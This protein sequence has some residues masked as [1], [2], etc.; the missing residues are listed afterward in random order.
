MTLIASDSFNR[1]NSTSAIGTADVGGTWSVPMP[2]PGDSPWGIASSKAY[3]V[4]PSSATFTTIADVPK[5][6]ALLGST[7]DP[8]IV[9]ADITFS[10]TSPNV[11]LVAKFVDTSN[12]IFVDLYNT[13]LQEI[14]VIICVGGTFG[15]LYSSS[16]TVT[17]G[18][19]YAV[20]FDVDAAGWTIRVNGTAIR[21]DTLSGPQSAALA[22]T[23]SAGLYLGSGLF[24]GTQ[25][26][27]PGDSRFDNYQF[28]TPSDTR[29]PR[30]SVGILI[31]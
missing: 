23:S 11:G 16:F 20:R 1:S 22:G 28:T 24:F 13:T 26:N 21:S 8:H 7:A 27:D 29:R 17:K 9:S 31:S 12:F 14:A 4:S 6:I 30:S 3:C 2:S 25:P 15:V 19:T 5:N 10:A 18:A